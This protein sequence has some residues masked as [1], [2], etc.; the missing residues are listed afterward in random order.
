MGS[1]RDSKSAKWNRSHSTCSL[2]GP[3]GT[4]W[5]C[6]A[7]GS[8][9]DFRQIRQRAAQRV[10]RGRS[11]GRV[12]EQGNDPLAHFLAE[13]HAPLIESIGAPGYALHEHAV[14]IQRQQRPE[15][16]RIEP[17]NNQQTYRPVA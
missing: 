2:S 17:F 12:T 6:A 14:L 4:D 1:R 13:F 10:A 3:E 7:A 9:P 5:T 15:R 11:G 16:A 8:D